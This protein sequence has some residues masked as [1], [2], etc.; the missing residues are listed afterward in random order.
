M[1]DKYPV[2]EHPELHRDILSQKNRHTKQKQPAKETKKSNNVSNSIV[3][4]RVVNFIDTGTT[5][6]I[7][8]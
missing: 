2:P 5:W 8:L 4:L 3:L 1:L 6:E 7:V